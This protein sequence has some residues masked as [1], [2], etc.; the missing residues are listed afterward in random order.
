MDGQPELLAVVLGIDSFLG[1]REGGAGPTLGLAPLM[2]A[3]L[4]FAHAHL[5]GHRHN[6]IAI[7]VALPGASEVLYPVA[8]SSAANEAAAERAAATADFASFDHTVMDRLKSFDP[9]RICSADD[10]PAPAMASALSRALCYVSRRTRATPDLAARM[11]VVQ[12]GRDSPAQYNAVMNCIFAAHSKEVPIDGCVLSTQTS[13]FLQQA[14][15]L[16]NGVYI[17]PPEQQARTMR[18]SANTPRLGLS[19]ASPRALS[20]A[21]TVCRH[22]S[23][24]PRQLG[25]LLQFLLSLFSAGTDCRK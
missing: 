5:L 9:E 19:H 6:Q 23:L 18:L 1:S 3:V 20:H 22:P 12:Q 24:P 4:T 10:A 13:T 17:Q 21:P 11:L 14:S 25:A 8:S 7:F 16:T 2:S 15:H